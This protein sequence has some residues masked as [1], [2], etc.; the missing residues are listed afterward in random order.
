MKDPLGGFGSKY[1]DDE[2]DPDRPARARPIVVYAPQYQPKLTGR[3]NAAALPPTTATA[4]MELAARELPATLALYQ[5][6]IAERTGRWFV[7]YLFVGLFGVAVPFWF[8]VNWTA[9]SVGAWAIA[10]G[11]VVAVGHYPVEFVREWIYTAPQLLPRTR[12]EHRRRHSIPP[13]PSLVGVFVVGGSMI[14][15]STVAPLVAAIV[16]GALG[17]LVLVYACY[18]RLRL[19]KELLPLYATYGIGG[20]VAPGVWRPRTPARDRKLH[21]A[22]LYIVFCLL[23]SV[24][25]M[26]VPWEQIFSKEHVSWTTALSSHFSTNSRAEQ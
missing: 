19:G 23:G 11:V 4:D 18:G 3:I 25:S 5:R 7:A 2:H 16:F 8:E 24:V 26:R 9:W 10:S 1:G 12:L 22:V 13:T 17:G 14:G 15:L 6:K 20:T 21:L